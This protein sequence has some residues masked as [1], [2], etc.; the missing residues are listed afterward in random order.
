MDKKN[1]ALVLSGGGARGLAHIGVIEELL[2]Q[3]YNITSVAGTSMGA[4]VGAFYAMNKMQ[5]FKEW[6]YTVDKKKI[7][8]LI[9]FSFGKQGLIKG[10]KVINAIKEIIP[11]VNIQDLEIP[12]SATAT[13]LKSKKEVVF[14][15]GSI[16]NAM[17][18][19][20]AIPSVFT[21][22]KTDNALLVDGGVVNNI[23][24]NN[25][26]RRNKDILIAVNVN[27]NIPKYQP[28]IDEI[29]TIKKQKIYKQKLIYFYRHLK[30]IS[31]LPHGDRMNYFN[32]IDQTISIMMHK[33]TE[34]QLEKY[35]LDLLIKVSRDTCSTFDFFKAEEIVEIGR[36]MAAEQ[37]VNLK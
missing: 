9:D 4:M 15:K 29:E 24:I 37:L 23:P 2:S 32:L 1:V 20:I 3:N 25:V 33:N 8:Q 28:K 36:I 11:D 31:I 7:F 22:V 27:A 17:R 21:P 13:D 5:D 10:D 14:T 35:S 18:A 16:Y 19:S 12:Y 30:K 34:L 26:K 6:I